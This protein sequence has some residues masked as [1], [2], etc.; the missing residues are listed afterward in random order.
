M[1]EIQAACSAAFDAAADEN[2]GTLDTDAIRD[3]LI[4]VLGDLKLTRG[5]LADV[6]KAVRLAFDRFI[7]PR[8]P[9]TF[10]DIA[11]FAL[12]SLTRILF[13]RFLPA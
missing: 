4:S 2:D 9:D 11:W 12:E 8:V 13:N 10:D 5:D 7:E 3:V 1:S 6:L